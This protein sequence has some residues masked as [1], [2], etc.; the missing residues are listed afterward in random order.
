MYDDHFIINN[1]V[2]G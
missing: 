1:V 2:N